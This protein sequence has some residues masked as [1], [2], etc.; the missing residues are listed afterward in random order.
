MGVL[1]GVPRRVFGGE[2][3]DCQ[4]CKARCCRYLAFPVPQTREAAEFYKAREI[5]TEAGWAFIN[6]KCPSLS[7]D[8]LCMR[9]AM[10]P[11]SCRLM[12]PD[13]SLCRLM[14]RCLE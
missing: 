1:Y 4:E 14:R 2:M 11:L 13:G 7:D 5:K 10:R 8:G 9:Y 6:L 3:N 12:K